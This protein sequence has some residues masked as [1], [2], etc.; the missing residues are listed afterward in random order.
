MRIALDEH[1]VLTELVREAVREW[2]D[3][4]TRRRSSLKSKER[5]RASK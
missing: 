2:L 3:R 1:T 4:R 5:K